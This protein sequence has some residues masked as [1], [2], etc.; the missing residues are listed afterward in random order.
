MSRTQAWSHDLHSNWRKKRHLSFS[1]FLLLS[2]MLYYF[3]FLYIFFAILII[4]IYK[5]FLLFFY[6]WFSLSLFY[7]LT[8]CFV[9]YSSENPPA[10]CISFLLSVVTHNFAL[11]LF[12]AV[13]SISGVLHL[14]SMIAYCFVC[15]FL[16][17]AKQFSPFLLFQPEGHWDAEKHNL[18]VAKHTY[19][20]KNEKEEQF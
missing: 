5:S 20:A 17:T 9:L 11:W 2:V 12:S 8:F 13:K 4:L 1:L 6:Y 14:L 16:R 7:C 15:F 19:N 18:F 3:F 10:R